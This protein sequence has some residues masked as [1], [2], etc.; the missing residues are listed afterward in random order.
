MTLLIHFSAGFAV[1]DL[2]IFKG[3]F[4]FNLKPETKLKKR[5]WFQNFKEVLSVFLKLA[6]SNPLNYPPWICK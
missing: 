1:V 2:E 4:H 3:D 6:L 5:K